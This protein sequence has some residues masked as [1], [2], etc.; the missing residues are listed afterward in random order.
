MSINGDE[1]V[2]RLICDGMLVATSLGSTAYSYSAGGVPCHPK[3]RSVAV[4]PISPHRPRLT[5]LVL[6]LHAVVELKALDLHRRPVRA[7]ADG[8][9]LGPVER[10]RVEDAQDEVRLAFL[11]S[12]DFTRALF[13]K[14][15]RA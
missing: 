1:V 13:R 4:T 7:V 11:E 10:I 6:P 14:V 2:E 3:V 8:V 15:L 9:D 5:P 12:H